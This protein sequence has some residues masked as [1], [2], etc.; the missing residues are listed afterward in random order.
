[1]TSP[2]VRKADSRIAVFLFILF[3]ALCSTPALAQ[4]EN[5]PAR[6]ARIS[7]LKGKVSFEPAGQDGWSEAT[8]NFTV[9]TGDRLYTDKGARAELEV[10]AYITRSDCQSKPA[11][12]LPTSMISSCNLDW[13]KG[14]SELASTSCLPAKPSKLTRQ[15][16]L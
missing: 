6:A 14:P 15:T 12:S 13:N 2:N 7:Y 16:V 11:L 9:T 4:E 5:P 1:M 10:G 3:T 8:R